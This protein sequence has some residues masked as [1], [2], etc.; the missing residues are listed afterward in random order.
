M[1]ERADDRKSRWHR[2]KRKRR[3]G[4]GQ[5]RIVA[6]HIR[7]IPVRVVCFGGGGMAGGGGKAG[8]SS[9]AIESN[10]AESRVLGF[11]NRAV[12]SLMEL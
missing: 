4:R 9:L 12:I 8:T 1:I 2:A 3:G 5:E 7:L 11:S 6:L 10:I